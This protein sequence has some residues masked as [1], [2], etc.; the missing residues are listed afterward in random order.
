MFVPQSEGPFHIID[1]VFNFLFYASGD[2]SLTY[3]FLY[4][5]FHPSYSYFIGSIDYSITLSSPQMTLIIDVKLGIGKNVHDL[6]VTIAVNLLEDEKNM[7]YKKE[8]M[9]V[10]MMLATNTSMLSESKIMYKLRT[11]V[12]EN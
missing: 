4:S 5:C 1:A 7:V 11:Q 3:H 6:H 2:L 10:D 9:H 12:T 8:I